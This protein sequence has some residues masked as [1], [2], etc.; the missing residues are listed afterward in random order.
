MRVVRRVVVLG[1]IA[2]GCA[3]DR[4]RAP[5][6]EPA[7]EAAPRV[8]PEPVVVAAPSAALVAAHAVIEATCGE[9][10][11]SDLETAVPAALAVFDLWDPQWLARL[12]DAAFASMMTRL[13]D[14]GVAP[15][16]QASV[17]AAIA[18]VQG[19]RLDPDCTRS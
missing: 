18:E 15:E 9:C 2:L 6:P 17:R 1:S 7:V 16:D 12:D 3:E 10:H 8:K 19:A 13:E 11:R 4:E 14:Q 5:A